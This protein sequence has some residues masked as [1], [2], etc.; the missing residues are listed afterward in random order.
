M[1]DNSNSFA[2]SIPIGI[3]IFVLIMALFQYKD[4]LSNTYFVL[5]LWIGYPLLLFIFT[6]VVNMSK[7]DS[8]IE[9]SI[10]GSL[11]SVLFIFIAFIISSISVCRIPIASVFTPL[12]IKDTEKSK[13]CCNNK[14]SLSDVENKYSV[15]KGM[16]YGFYA[17]FATFFGIIIGNSYSTIRIDRN[18][19]RSTI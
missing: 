2:I 18:I 1:S 5:M 19:M 16:S 4:I 13:G 10:I 15:I 17:M 12:F 11:P 6:F 9:S 3:F 8:T 14:L 7:E